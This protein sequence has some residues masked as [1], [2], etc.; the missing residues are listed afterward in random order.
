MC[1]P[2]R[3]EGSLDTHIVIL[4]AKK[5]L[6]MTAFPSDLQKWPVNNEGIFGGLRRNKHD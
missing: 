5:A 3:S 6:R 4:R 1:H 2:E